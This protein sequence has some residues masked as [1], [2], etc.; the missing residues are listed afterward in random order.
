MRRSLRVLG[1][2]AGALVTAVPLAC[3]ASGPHHPRGGAVAPSRPA[4]STPSPST[5]PTTTA[6]VAPVPATGLPTLPTV[7]PSDAQAQQELFTAAMVGANAAPPDGIPSTWSWA[8]H[9]EVDNPSNPGWAAMT[10]WGQ[11]Y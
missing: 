2:V 4:T 7:P 9:A 5:A 11:V 1:G 8:Q 10:A 6:R 3:S